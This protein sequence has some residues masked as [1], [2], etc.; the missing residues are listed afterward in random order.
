MDLFKTV[1]K[2]Y[3]ALLNVCLFI[4]I[5]LVIFAVMGESPGPG[6]TSHLTNDSQS[7]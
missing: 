4:F 6:H 5:W 3:H 7:R 1:A 2:S